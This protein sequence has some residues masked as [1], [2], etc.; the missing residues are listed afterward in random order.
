MA[1]KNVAK[2][3]ARMLQK[4]EEGQYYEAHQQLRVVSQRYIKA[5]DF[6]SAIDIL[7]SGAQSLS[8]ASQYSSAGDLCLLLVEVYKTAKII[9][10]ASSKSRLIEL[11][12]ALP[13]SEPTRKRLINESLAWS[14]KLGPFPAG[15]PELHHFIG[16]LLLPDDLYAAEPHFLVGTKESVDVFTNALYD[17][18]KLDSDKS[19]AGRYIGRAVF[20]YLLV[21]NLRDAN[22]ALDLFS[23]KLLKDEEPVDGRSTADNVARVEGSVLEVAV[24][25]HVPA[26]NFLRLLCLGCQTGG[27]DVFEKLR[28]RYNTS[29]IK[30]AG[31]EEPMSMI[32]QVY[33]GIEIPRAF[34]PMDM[35]GGLFGG[36]GNKAPR[37]IEGIMD[38]D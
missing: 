32:G 38:M 35:L 6:D 9:P 29:V 36:G 10:D 3:R 23:E 21:K 25:N 28:S 15:D 2:T 11:L 12:T 33:F 30:P 7:F 34:N 18:Y 4:I 37:G 22:R 1:S 5:N 20:G 8:K 31:W 13:A 19:N 24:I 27:R 16:N 14:S 17:W 26:I